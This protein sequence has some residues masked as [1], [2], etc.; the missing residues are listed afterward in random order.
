MFPG[1][2][3]RSRTEEYRERKDGHRAEPFARPVGTRRH[4]LINRRSA[5]R[6]STLGAEPKG[7]SSGKRRDADEPRSGRAVTI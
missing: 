3:P 4:P 7:R 1:T 5:N 2:F 6:P